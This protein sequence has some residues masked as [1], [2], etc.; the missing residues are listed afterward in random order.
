[1]IAGAESIALKA[2]LKGLF[3]VG[4][5]VPVTALVEKLISRRSQVASQGR[6]RKEAYAAARQDVTEWLKSLPDFDTSMGVAGGVPT[7]VVYK[8]VSNDKGK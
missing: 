7:T 2:D 3:Q 5:T 8:K 1:M 4:S 6:A